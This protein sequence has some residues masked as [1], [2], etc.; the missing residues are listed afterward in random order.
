MIHAIAV[1][2]ISAV[3][4]IGSLF[5]VA[6]VQQPALVLQSLG[7]TLP[8]GTAVFEASLQSR[9]SSTD[10]SMTLVANSV[11]GGTALTGFQCF[12]VDEG[13]TDAEYICGTISGTRSPA[14]HAA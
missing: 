5:G 10:T 14:S 7:A 6:T 8:S 2:F 13:R 12:T 9:I 11:R 4:F 1:A 3:A